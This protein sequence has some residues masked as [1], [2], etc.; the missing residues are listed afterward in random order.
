[1]LTHFTCTVYS[2]SLCTCVYTCACV[3]HAWSVESIFLFQ[4]KYTC[5]SLTHRHMHKHP[6]PPPPPHTHTHT[7]SLSLSY[8]FTCVHTHTRD[9]VRFCFGP[10]LQ[11]ELDEFR[12]DWNNQFAKVHESQPMASSTSTPQTSKKR[13]QE[14]RLAL[15]QHYHDISKGK[16]TPTLDPPPPKCSNTPTTLQPATEK[17]ISV[18]Y[19]SRMSERSHS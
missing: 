17:N 15:F 11:K 14:S 2:R 7:H 5:S 8:I 19:Y 12:E 9:A 10:M 4:F 6:P 1:M 16:R 13:M 18:S 3:L